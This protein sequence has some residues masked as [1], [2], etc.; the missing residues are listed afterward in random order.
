MKY[1]LLS[2]TIVS[3]VFFAVP[4]TAQEG[5]QP[6]QVKDA[7]GIQDIVV[8]AQRRDENLQKAA[9]AVSVIGGDALSQAGVSKAQDLSKLVPALK[10]SSAGGGGT[11]V[12]IRGALLHNFA[13][14]F[15]V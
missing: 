4:A 1:I 8:T 2:T 6:N 9:L 10:L 15:P 12:T 13:Q 7:T 11:Q 14:G 5:P 3:G